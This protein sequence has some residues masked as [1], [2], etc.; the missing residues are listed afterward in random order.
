MNCYYCGKLLD[1][2]DPKVAPNEHPTRRQCAEC[3][4]EV[5]LIMGRGQRPLLNLLTKVMRN[6]VEAPRPPLPESLA[7]ALARM[8]ENFYISMSVETDTDTDDGGQFLSACIME[9]PPVEGWTI[10][11]YFDEP[12][13]VARSHDEKW[14]EPHRHGD[15]ARV[16]IS[17]SI[18][19]PQSFDE[20]LLK[21]I[22]SK[23]PAKEQA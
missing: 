20:L 23:W 6:P 17:A 12:P 4:V 1:D 15:I 14:L 3:A 5:D 10:P 7:T 9:K 18:D 21:M 8:P 16:G 22:S 2:L 13:G 11:T 19:D